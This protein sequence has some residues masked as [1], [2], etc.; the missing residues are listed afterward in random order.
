MKEFIEILKWFRR[1]IYF[2][3]GLIGLLFLLFSAYTYIAT[4]FGPHLMKAMNWYGHPLSSDLASILFIFGSC[5]PVLTA[6]AVWVNLRALPRFQKKELAVVFAPNFCE[7][8]EEDVNKVFIALRQELKSHEFGNR[9]SLK[10]LPPNRSINSHDDALKILAK[11]NAVVA[12]WGIFEKQENGCDSV[13]GFQRLAFTFHHV[14]LILT[15][16][17]L[18]RIQTPMIGKK[19]QIESKDFFAGH[20]LLVRNVGFVV[21]NMIGLALYV[22]ADYQEAIKVFL[23]LAGDLTSAVFRNPSVELQSFLFQVKHDCAL[24]M[25]KQMMPDY[26]RHLYS[27]K[28]YSIAPDQWALWI[29]QLNEAIKISPQSV[30]PYLFKSIS[31]FMLGEIDKSIRAARK[32]KELDRKA[33]AAPNFSLAFLYN[34]I[35]DYKKSRRE[36]RLGMAKENSYEEGL[37]RE[38]LSF[39]RQTIEKYPEKKQLRLAFGLISFYRSDKDIAAKEIRDFLM[40][41]DTDPNLVD[42]SNE[43]KRLLAEVA[44]MPEVDSKAEATA[45]DA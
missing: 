16:D 44:S 18:T 42:F 43:G 33:F 23:K 13:T 2:V 45:P 25:T 29:Q 30:G 19:W 17:W 1:R 37:I 28:L 36:Y 40:A 39:I 3:D 20:Q 12:V 11:C 8:L 26:N 6:I 9:F 34:F 7:N 10:K 15:K 4:T 24:A 32:A 38:C 41:A 27:G 5:I 35:G 22:A 31:H 21:R 14:P